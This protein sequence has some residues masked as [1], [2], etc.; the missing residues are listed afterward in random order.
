[1]PRA[2]PTAA[3]AFPTSAD[4]SIAGALLFLAD[5][6]TA[7]P[8]PTLSD[9]LSAYSASSSH[10]VTSA[11]SCVSDSARRGRRI[12]PLRVLY[13]VASLRCIDPKVLAKATS[14][15]FLGEAPKKRKG[16]WI[17]TSDDEDESERG[18]TAASEGSAITAAAS[19]GSTA[20]SGRCRRPP[21]VTGGGVNMPGRAKRI[22]EWLSRPKAVPATETA[23]RAAVGDTG[24]TSKALRWL[25]TQKRGLRRAGTGGHADPFVYMV[26]S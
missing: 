13:V 26:A 17:Q 20:T 11:R 19:A 12:D 14:K 25:L 7:P 8:L 5:S 4:V 21:R 15:L 9:E 23:I 6:S 22:M 1:M 3:A 18:S 2:P 16:V 24:H 10:S